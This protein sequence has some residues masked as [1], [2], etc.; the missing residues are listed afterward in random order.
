MPSENQRG[1]GAEHNVD[2]L[3]YSRF[4]AGKTQGVFL[5]VGAARPDFLSV[6]ELFRS[7]G[8]RVLAFEPNPE[9]AA[10]H[11]A[12]GHEVYEIACGPENREDVEFSVADSKGSAYRG[13]NVSYESFSSLSLK[14]GY[15]KLL[16]PTVE[17]RKIRVRMRRLDDV[18]AEAGISGVDVVSVDVEGWE[19]EV[20]AGLDLARHRPSVLVIENFLDDPG[21][22]RQLAERGY[23][24][25]QTLPPNQV[26]VR[27]DL[28]KQRSFLDRLRDRVEAWRARRAS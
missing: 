15:A 7:Q 8:W 11:R 2:R 13:G 5:D 19:L 12:R 20:L 27:A 16:P 1:A 4:F 24:L 6:S 22:V 18:L 28:L 21:Y 25:W 14:E 3:V 9:F 10:M 26:F 17:L 23:G